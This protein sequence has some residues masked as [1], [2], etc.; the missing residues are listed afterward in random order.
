[1]HPVG[2]QLATFTGQN[3]CRAIASALA[4][5]GYIEPD[6]GRLAALGLGFPYGCHWS[7][8]LSGTVISINVTDDGPGRWQLVIRRD[9]P[10]RPIAVSKRKASADGEKEATE[11]V[12]RMA[13]ELH[14]VLR[15]VCE[16]LTWVRIGASGDAASHLEP[17][18]PDSAPD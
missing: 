11:R 1:M 5:K 15:S 13:Q 4:S 14:P 17:I 16:D 8:T 6:S 9:V 10:V 2:S 3:P 7:L 12:Y 18:P